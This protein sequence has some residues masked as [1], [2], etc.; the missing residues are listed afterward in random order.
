M[1]DANT[2]SLMTMHNYPPDDPNLLRHHQ[3]ITPGPSDAHSPIPGP[4]PQKCDA[5]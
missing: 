2:N 4:L 1:S 3:Y 5:G